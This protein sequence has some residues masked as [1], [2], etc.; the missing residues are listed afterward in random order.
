[1]KN[2]Q[3]S[4]NQVPLENIPRQVEPTPKTSPA[5]LIAG[6]LVLAV[7]VVLLCLIPKPEN[8]LFFELRIGTDILRTHHL[9]HFDTY[10][11]TNRGTRWDVPEWLTFIIYALAM[12]HAGWFGVWLVVVAAT[13]ATAWIVWIWL[14]RRLD[15]AWGMLLTNLMLLAL[16]DFIQE[17]PYA[18]TYLFLALSLVIL[19]KAREGRPRLLL[20]LPPLCVLW[21][22][23]HQGV[24]VLVCILV[25]Y[26]LVDFVAWVTG[27]GGLLVLPT[28]NGH[29]SP[30]RGTSELGRGAGGE[31]SFGTSA[32]SQ[33]GAEGLSVRGSTDVL[34]VRSP[35]NWGVGGQFA[36]ALACALAVMAS[37]YG[38]RVY[39]NVFITLRDPATMSHVTEWRPITVVPFA[40]MDAFLLI[41]ILTAAPLVLNRRRP[42]TLQD[43]VILGALLIESVLHARN[44]AIFAIGATVIGRPHFEAAIARVRRLIGGSDV[45][46]GR[47]AAKM[48][49]AVV[50]VLYLF[51]VAAVAVAS[52]KSATGP[53]GYSAAGIGEAV[54]REP[55]YPNAACD[56][57]RRE[58]FPPNLRLFNN[59]SLGGFLMWRL[60]NEPDFVDGR[61]DVF[62]GR[63]FDDTLT[64]DHDCG[65]PT[66]LAL[67]RRY[68]FDCV[69]TTVD[70]VSNAFARQTDWAVVYQDNKESHHLRC[71]IL[72]R[73]RPRFA[74]LIA[75]CRRDER[76]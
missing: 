9:P 75:R 22:N 15:F 33:S 31:G 27:R 52:L 64:L 30:K 44:M 60:P 42:G 54:A 21:T 47:L 72:L 62:T 66:W 25:A 74:A 26:S 24:I 10:S 68:D 65:S 76:L 71:V 35:E 36:T 45:G 73:R 41:A 17:R 2:V 16:S 70:R 59:F 46:G 61:L 38:W 3:K 69:I 37:P 57:V 50:G 8:D 20:W 4:N 40:Q 55:S 53:R 19:T 67:V 18:F 39:W 5:S 43:A 63:I 1:L 56:F 6:A 51:M 7:I 28:S 14:A 58:G 34:Q 32:L 29:P 23:L 11:W 49:F 13:L 48:A 12:Q